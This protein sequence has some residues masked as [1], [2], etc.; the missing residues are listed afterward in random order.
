M[1]ARRRRGQRRG[2]APTLPTRSF[3]ATTFNGTAQT[4]YTFA[5]QNIGSA[6]ANRYVIVAVALYYGPARTISSV[7]VGGVAATVIPNG[8]TVSNTFT[9]RMA[10]YIAAVPT[11]TT[12]SVVVT[13]SGA[14]DACAISV[15]SA[16]DLNSATAVDSDNDTGGPSPL[17]APSV[18]TSAD[19]FLLAAGTYVRNTGTA[20]FGWTNAT[21]RSD[22]SSSFSGAT[23]GNSAA[24]ADTNGAGVAVSATIAGTIDAGVLVVASFR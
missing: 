9:Y 15:W 1:I 17:S 6:S 24:D 21:E 8:V 14:C 5:S 16:Y 18:N 3:Q 2:V 19:G 20:A 22:V 12:A 4:T 10:F 13:A 23:A 7:T 11:G